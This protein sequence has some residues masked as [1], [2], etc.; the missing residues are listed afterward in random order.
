MAHL[1]L[2]RNN[3]FCARTGAAQGSAAPICAVHD[4]NLMTRTRTHAVRT[5]R[6]MAPAGATRQRVASPETAWRQ[7][8]QR[9]R[10][11][12]A[13]PAPPF[14]RRGHA[15]RVR[16]ACASPNGRKRARRFTQRPQASRRGYS[17]FFAGAFS[18]KSNRG[19][20]S[21]TRWRPVATSSGEASS[22]RLW[23]S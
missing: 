9:A 18:K 4:A 13:P 19:G 22:A 1:A 12:A 6:C 16:R 7:A 8:A 3:P 14:A 2:W 5:H 10:R 17:A 15:R 20:S 23:K 11:C 21:F